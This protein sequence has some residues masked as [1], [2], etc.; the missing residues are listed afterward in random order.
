MKEKIFKKVYKNLIKNLFL[1]KFK[2]VNLCF[3]FAIIYIINK[4]LVLLKNL[5][6]YLKD[7]TFE[8]FFKKY[9][10]LFKKKSFFTTYNDG[11]LK[12]EKEKKKRY[13]K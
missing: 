10:I 13:N 5:V 9:K 7:S 12:I 8:C 11:K 4:M 2:N 6:N 1:E 3:S